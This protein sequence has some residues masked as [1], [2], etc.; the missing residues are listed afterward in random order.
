MSEQTR[1]HE[2]MRLQMDYAHIQTLKGIDANQA[3]AREQATVLSHALQQAKIEIVGGD[4][5]YFEKFMNSLSLGK[6]IDGAISKSTLL[7]QATKDHR[8]GKRDL[9]TDVKEIVGALGG[10]SAEVR[11]LSVTSLIQQLLAS[12]KT[13]KAGLKKLVDGM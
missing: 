7:S 6:S 13:D 12:G 10:A 11:D 9:V 3:I 2:E 4:G 1:A 8:S 5:D